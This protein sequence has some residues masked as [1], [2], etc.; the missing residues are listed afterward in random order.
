ML[1]R[2]ERAG[3]GFGSAFRGEN[4]LKAKNEIRV[5]ACSAGGK[6]NKFG[7]ALRR[8]VGRGC[9]FRGVPR[10]QRCLGYRHTDQPYR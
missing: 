8:R 10:A 5:L 1:F 2:L 9:G 6:E 4:F 7:H 3:L